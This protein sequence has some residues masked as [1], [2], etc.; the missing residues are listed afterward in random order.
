M[1]VIAMVEHHKLTRSG[2]NNSWCPFDWSNI[3][4]LF[5][6]VF[7]TDSITTMLDHYLLS[8][9]VLNVIAFWWSFCCCS[10]SG[11]SCKPFLTA[12]VRWF[13]MIHCFVCYD[14]DQLNSSVENPWCNLVQTL[15]IRSW[16]REPTKIK[17]WEEWHWFLRNS[18]ST[19]C[20][21]ICK[22]AH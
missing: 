19:K 14:F 15:N 5:V 4:L 9:N 2:L 22:N 3:F 18:I 11:I 13:V 6:F 21:N 10:F 1:N 16:W 12:D 20:W 8:K 7:T 17:E